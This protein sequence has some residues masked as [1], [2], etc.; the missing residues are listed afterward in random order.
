MRFAGRP[1][2]VFEHAGVSDSLG[3]FFNLNLSSGA[4]A[5]KRLSFRTDDSTLFAL[6]SMAAAVAGGATRFALRNDELDL[7][8][9]W[10]G[11]PPA[12]TTLGEMGNLPEGAPDLRV[13]HLRKALDSAVAAGV[14]QVRL[15][16]WDGQHGVRLVRSRQGLQWQILKLDPFG[17]SGGGGWAVR[18]RCLESSRLRTLARAV[19][20]MSAAASQPEAQALRD[21][22]AWCGPELSADRV[23]LNEEVQPG[24]VLGWCVLAPEQPRPHLAPRFARPRGGPELLPRQT[25]PFYAQ[26]S[27]GAQGAEPGVQAVVGGVVLPIGHTLGIRDCSVVLAAEGLECDPSFTRLLPTPA[28]DKVLELLEI[29][30]LRM[31]RELLEQQSGIGYDGAE[32][33]GRIFADLAAQELRRE[34]HEVALRAL[35]ASLEL[36]EGVLG[37][38]H[39]DLVDGWCQLMDWNARYGDAHQ[40]LALQQ[41]LIPLLRASGENHL[42]KHRVAEGASQLRRAL[43]LEETLPAESRPPDLARRFHELAQLLKDNRLPGAEELFSRSLALQQA[44]ASGSPETQLDI[45]VELADRHRGNRRYPE[46]ELK[47]REALTLA[48]SLHGDSSKEL[49]RPLKLLADILKASNRYGEATDY[50]SRAMLL[51]FRR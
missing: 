16:T 34:N 23:P 9:E 6:H 13:R 38:A 47:A 29:Y 43:E 40:S 7:V 15:E 14:A 46:A 28:L 35:R 3:K 31:A 36:R 33:A 30:V 12:H 49:I 1:P 42:R 41:R 11:E 4:G 22:C 39:P 18:I 8:M 26:L 10:N 48:E 21:R 5:G 27:L 17:S 32:V 2:A 37:A 24:R 51:R 50:E 25:V 45:L 20:Q 44:S 19:G